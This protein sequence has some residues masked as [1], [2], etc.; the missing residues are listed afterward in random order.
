MS[1]NDEW[2]NVLI[3]GYAKLMFN[4]TKPNFAFYLH[5][6]VRDF[7]SYTTINL[8]LKMTNM[9]FINDKDKRNMSAA[10]IAASHG[11]EHALQCLLDYG[12]HPYFKVSISYTNIHRFGTDLVLKCK[13]IYFCGYNILHTASQNG[14]IQIVE[15]LVER[16]NDKILSTRNSMNLTAFELAVENG[17]TVVTTYLLNKK[18][19]FANLLALHHSA[20]NG[21]SSIVKLLL[22]NGVKDTCLLCK[23]S[24]YW[25]PDTHG[26]MQQDFDIGNVVMYGNSTTEENYKFYDDW[27]L[28]T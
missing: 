10:F 28:I 4:D 9:K 16:Y 8:L 23:D 1:G 7:N 18:T 22:E 26:R 13:N 20:E 12:A 19:S 5:Q 3:H 25:I 21:H 17:H 27:Y 6:A 15:M 2:K 24:I 11:N 14:H